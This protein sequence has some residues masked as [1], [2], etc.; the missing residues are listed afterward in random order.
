MRASVSTAVF[1]LAAIAP[2]AQGYHLVD[3][4]VG[5]NFLSGFFH[6]AVAD[7]THGRV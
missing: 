1:A 3:N 6:Q 7:P 2:L 4:F 5:K